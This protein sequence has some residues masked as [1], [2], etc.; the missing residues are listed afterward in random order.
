[1][2]G[3]PWCSVPAA[4]C[5]N[6]SSDEVLLAARRVADNGRYIESAIAQ[7]LALQAVSSVDGVLTERDI[8]IMRL[9]ADGFSL[10]E[11]ADTLG[12]G[13]KTVANASSQIKTR[14]GVTRTNDRVRLALTLGF[15]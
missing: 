6:A 13:Y 14:L 15:A 9:M 12:I 2:R 3:V 5:K 11:I 8:E 10:S 4:I 1:M 7:E